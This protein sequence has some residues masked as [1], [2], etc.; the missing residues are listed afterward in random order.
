MKEPVLGIYHL[1]VISIEQGYS[2]MKNHVHQ[3]HTPLQ[4]ELQYNS[5][6]ITVQLKHENM[7][8]NFI[9]TMSS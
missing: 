5:Y 1:F 4:L 3:N 2:N 9:N 6:T 7:G 8:N